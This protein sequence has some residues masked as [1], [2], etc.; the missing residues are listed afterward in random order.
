LID[1]RNLETF[2]WVAR[3]RKFHLAAEKLNTTQ[4]AIS[5]RIALLEQDLGKRLFDR[6]ARSAELTA[7]GL[8]LLGYAERMLALRAEMLQAF[9]DRTTYRGILRIGVPET[10]VHTWLALLVERIAAEYPAVTLDIE[11]D[12]TVN[13]H[14]ALVNEKLGLAFLYHP[15][16]EEGLKCEG[17]CSYSLG[18]FARPDFPLRDERLGITDLASRPVITFRR[19]SPAYAA[20]AELMARFGLSHGRIFGSSAI[21]AIIRMTLDQIGVCVLPD[22]V[23]QRE[24]DEGKL[25]R[26]YVDCPLPTLDF[27]VC[28]R[29]KPDDRLPSV[30]AAMA[31]ST[32]RGY[33]G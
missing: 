4:P 26:L 1:L 3:L 27:H 20:V 9:E 33:M 6:R 29:E 23:V 11:V 32:A 21:A 12:S 10:I 30:V 22:A 18:W 8:E 7:A 25:R 5:A 19:G 24:V 13:L 17:L 16:S 28:Y 31:I 15:G 2:L 14:R